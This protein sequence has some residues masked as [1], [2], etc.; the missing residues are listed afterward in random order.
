MHSLG[1]DPGSLLTGCGTLAELLVC[2][3]V[4]T[5]VMPRGLYKSILGM[6]T[7]VYDTRYSCY[8]YLSSALANTS[9]WP[10]ALLEMNRGKAEL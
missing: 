2:A 3:S 8:Y 4:M 1:L 9:P 7:T 5:T 6:F 10:L